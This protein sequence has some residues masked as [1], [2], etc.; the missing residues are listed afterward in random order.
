MASDEAQPLVDRAD[1]FVA[2]ATT[3]ARSSHGLLALA[4]VSAAALALWQGS[5]RAPHEA[6]DLSVTAPAVD[7]PQHAVGLSVTAPAAD[8]S[9]EMSASIEVIVNG[10]LTMPLFASLHVVLSDVATNSCT[11][12]VEYFP[13]D[14]NATALPSLWT[15]AVEVP[16]GS[17][18]A[19]ASDAATPGAGDTVL[20][21]LRLRPSTNYVARLFVVD[22]RTQRRTQ[23]ASV[24]WRSSSTGVPRFDEGPLAS[25]EPTIYPPTWQMVTFVYEVR[26]WR[27]QRRPPRVPR[28]AT[29]A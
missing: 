5:A 27:S 6:A 21:V 19:N 28:P 14:A 13:S 12:A 23:K 15:P 16:I 7:A 1:G 29:T 11:I 10:G 22:A 2:R 25:V 9:V 18:G 4:A 26:S 24:R 17:V 20:S 8:T 3:K